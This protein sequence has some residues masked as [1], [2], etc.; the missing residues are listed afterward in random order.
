MKKSLYLSL[1]VLLA[2]TSSFSQW[3]VGGNNLPVGG[4]ALGSNNNRPVIFETNNIERARLLSTSGFWG[5]GLVA[6]NAQV[7][8]NATAAGTNPFQIDVV[9]VARM[10]VNS[11][12]Q[13]GIGTTLPNTRLHINSDAG[14]NPF[15]VQVAGL[16]KLYVDAGGG[17]SVGSSAI[18]PANGLY[19]SGNAGIGTTLPEG[20]LHV[21]RGSAGAVTANSNAP[22]VIENSTNNY[23]NLLTPSASERGIL[24][25]DNLN[26]ADGGIIYVGTSNTL[27]FRTNGN[28]TRMSLSDAGNLDIAGGTLSFGSVETLADA[29]AN[30]ISANSTFVPSTD[31]VRDLGTSLLRWNEVW[32]VDGTINTSDLRDKKNVEELKYGL[33]EIMQLRPVKFQWNSATASVSGDKFGVIA[34][35]IQKVLPQVVRDYEYKINEETGAREK[36][37]AARMGVMYADIIPVLIK[38]MQEQQKII[39]ELQERLVKVESG[40]VAA[41]SLNTSGL[42]ASSSAVLEQNKP[43]PFNQSTTIRYSIPAGANGQINIYDA[44]GVLV[45]TMRANNSGQVQVNA[46]ELRSG[47][48]TYSLLIDGKLIASKKMIM[49]Q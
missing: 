9:N 4:G 16:S 31:N 27:Q 7:H 40:S 15:R 13:V 25:G 30:T 18:P 43:N 45:K 5:F 49:L 11:N 32:A 8:I 39:N 48:Y 46:G 35:E 37:P 23:I 24:F 47:S 3:T 36:V 6:P 21:L 12:G 42:M 17:V 33:K 28:I 20:N 2:G 41:S 29:G 38:G 1:V 19:V 22:L 10:I 44:T 26:A 34:Q 14:E